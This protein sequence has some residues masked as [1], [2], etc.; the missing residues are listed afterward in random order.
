ML[1]GNQQLRLAQRTG[2]GLTLACLDLDGLKTINDTFGHAEGDIAIVQTA[3]ILRTSFRSADVL[4]RLGGDEFVALAID[5]DAASETVLLERLRGRLHD[6]N[7]VH[8]RGYRLSFSTGLAHFDPKCWTSLE[9]LMAQAD[10]K[11]YSQKAGGHADRSKVL[12]FAAPWTRLVPP[13]EPST[14]LEGRG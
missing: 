8:C 4:A 2:R 7:L 9:H 5:T 13:P 12:S 3:D 10:R 6:Y 11:L 1:L 14:F